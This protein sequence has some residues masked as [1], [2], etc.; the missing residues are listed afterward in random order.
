MRARLTIESGQAVPPVCDISPDGQPVVRLGRNG[1]NT[2]V[3]RDRHA[4][5]WHAEIAHENGCWFLRDCGT[6]N[7]T[8]L[9]GLRVEQ[10]TALKNGQEIRIGDT[11]FRFRLE[12]P[13]DN[14]AEMP[15]IAAP[16]AE[17][18]PEPPPAFVEGESS[19]ASTILRPDELNALFTFMD[20]S[21]GEEPRDLVGLA[22]KTIQQQTGANVCGFLSLDQDDPLP[23]MV[24]PD[25]V[26]VNTHLSRQLTLRVQRSG[27]TVWLAAD[28]SAAAAGG[29]DSILSYRDALCVPV[30]GGKTPQGA[31]HVYKSGCL[32]GPREVR[33]CEVLAGYLGKSLY[34]LR[35]RR[36]LEAD[37]SRLRVHA[38][39]GDQDLIGDSP[40]MVQLRQQIRRLADHPRVVL[41][42]GESG[43]GKELVALALHR[44]SSR[45]EGSLVAVNCAAIAA[46]M[47]EAELFGHCKGSF[48]GAD[49]DR[50][51][52][53]QQADMGTLFLD[54]IGELSE[55]C[56]AKFL[57]V[58]E[59]GSFRPVGAKAELKADV[60]ILAATNRDLKR[61]CLESNFRRDLFFRLG[62]EIRVPPLRERREDIPALVEY[63]LAKLAV[64]YKRSVRLSAAAMQRLQDYPWPGN[65]R[66]LRSVLE[67]AVAMSESNVV[68]A[69]ELHLFTDGPAPAPEGQPLALNL[70]ELET[71][72]IRQALRRTQGTITQAARLLGI[73]RDT[74]MLKMK[75]K[76]I[77]RRE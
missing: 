63:F 41:I 68:A 20:G 23:R 34:V 76:N 6:T 27:K 10:A 46:S 61:E 24:L 51:G 9:D 67:H 26:A 77:E 65:V 14:T 62:V 43:A 71:W 44:L 42:S 1:K 12:P 33:F 69:D 49:R 57:R 21:L 58:L 29:S 18:E 59:T 13:E 17:A 39:G 4:S 40:P 53:F 52:Y 35:T 74:L 2:I 3:L 70:E 72:A 54:E 5:R 30:P 37:N 38:S 45:R 15:S 36:A 48:T 73:H 19:E 25:P 66:Q 64:E 50:P 22:L 7:G 75:K 31:L 28:G 16:A 32:F 8:R 60:R 47:P 11:S 56:Q 55:E